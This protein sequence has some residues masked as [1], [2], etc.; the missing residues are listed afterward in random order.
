[1][2]QENSESKGLIGRSRE[3]KA[4]WVGFGIVAVPLFLLGLSGGNV[5]G[6]V[7]F[8][9]GAGAVGYLVFYAVAKLLG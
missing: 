9:L 4:G 3:D 6:S 8:A 2:S 7:G 1:M 5:A